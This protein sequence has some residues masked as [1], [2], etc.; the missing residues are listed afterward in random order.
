MARTYQPGLFRR[1]RWLTWAILLIAALHRTRA[2]VDYATQI[3]PLLQEPCYPF[4]GDLTARTAEVIFRSAM[5]VA[6][7]EAA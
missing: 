6:L 5:I 2:A 7:L 4:P 1:I 3:R